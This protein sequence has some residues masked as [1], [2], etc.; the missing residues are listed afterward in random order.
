MDIELP[1][2]VEGNPLVHGWPTTSRDRSVT[3]ESLDIVAARRAA[4][5]AVGAVRRGY[6][7]TTHRVT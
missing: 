2:T 3:C 5:V 4:I 6:A 1:E 7:G